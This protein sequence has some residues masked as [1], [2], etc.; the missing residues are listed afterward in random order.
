MTT[1]LTPV[2]ETTAARRHSECDCCGVSNETIRRAKFGWID[3]TSSVHT[4]GGMTVSLCSA[5]WSRAAAMFA[6]GDAEIRVIIKDAVWHVM[7]QHDNE[8]IVEADWT[9]IREDVA[10]VA[11]NTLQSRMSK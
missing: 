11:I 4:G 6:V 1:P 3:P 2:I 8:S 7:G 9:Q 10:Q 5:C